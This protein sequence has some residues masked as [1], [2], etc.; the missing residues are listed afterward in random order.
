M[1]RDFKAA[2]GVLMLASGFRITKIEMFPTGDMIPIML[3][4]MPVIH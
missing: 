1:I 2:G 4:I 3:V